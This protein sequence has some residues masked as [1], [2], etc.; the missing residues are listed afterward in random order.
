MVANRGR[1]R[2]TWWHCTVLPDLGIRVPQRWTLWGV[3]TVTKGRC[4][5]IKCN[6]LLLAPIQLTMRRRPLFS[7]S[8][9]I[10][11]ERHL[12]SGPTGRAHISMFVPHHLVSENGQ[13]DEQPVRPFDHSLKNSLMNASWRGSSREIPSSKVRRRSITCS[14]HFGS[15]DAWNWI[16]ENLTAVLKAISWYG[17]GVQSFTQVSTSWVSYL[18]KDQSQFVTGAIR[19]CIQAPTDICHMI[20]GAR[21]IRHY[22]ILGG[23]D[24]TVRICVKKE[25]TWTLDF[26]CFCSRHKKKN[27]L[28]EPASRSRST[29]RH[30]FVWCSS[31]HVRIEFCWDATLTQQCKL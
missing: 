18:T 5:N 12:Q 31:D 11:L 22:A 3:T 16:Y 4:R 8:T 30:A 9:L 29:K 24:K 2:V 1:G 17:L 10:W 19:F 7:V 15:P 28:T 27:L 26:W 13:M 20:C 21:S 25:K 23:R 6:A 14:K